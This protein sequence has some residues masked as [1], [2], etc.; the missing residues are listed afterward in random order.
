MKLKGYSFLNTNLLQLN[1]QGGNS[2]TVILD[3]HS[4]RVITRLKVNTISKVQH[5]GIWLGTDYDSGETLII[6]NHYRYGSAHI[7]TRQDFAAGQQD[8]WKDETCSNDWLTVI[9]TALNHV[10]AG[11]HYSVLDY[12]CQSFTNTACNNKSMSEDVRKWGGIAVG[13]LATLLLIVAIFNPD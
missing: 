7:A 1:F 5:T 11:R 9:R 2:K 13:G 6:H 12:N 8:Y 3:E 4:G 10:V